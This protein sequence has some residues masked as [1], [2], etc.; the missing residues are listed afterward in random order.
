[1]IQGTRRF[2]PRE[3]IFSKITAYDC[4]RWYLGNFEVNQPICNRLRNESNP[5]MV[6]REDS[7]ELYHFDAG[8]SR[9]R[10][11]CVNL[12]M[13]KYWCDYGTALRWI[14]KDFGLSEDEPERGSHV[15]TWKQPEGMISHRPPRIH[16]VTRTF[17]QAEIRWWSDRLVGIEDLKG[18]H[19]YAPKQIY[20]NLSRFP[21]GELMTF[22][23]Y[24]PDVD[25]WKIYRPNAP[26]KEKSTPCN[27][28]KWDS[29]LNHSYCEHITSLQFANS[30]L[31]CGKKKDRLYLQA[32]LQTDKICNVQAEDPSCLSE[33]TLHALNDVP[34]MW[35]NGDD[36]PKGHQFTDF[37]QNRGFKTING[38]MVDLGLEKGH[39][40]VKQLFI[41]K[42]WN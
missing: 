42:G 13:Q 3:F 41:N 17:T 36:D 16:V 30:G 6:I 4:Y 7:G 23:Y 31:L 33:E 19:V 2:S 14:M 37:L 18:E 15:I 24:Y 25:S 29:N 1:M 5:S 40:F 34:Q 27:Q 10:G 11:D 20:R 12:V 35:G 28:W 39:D 32:L 8:D 38:D 26:K 21:V 22:C 9:Y